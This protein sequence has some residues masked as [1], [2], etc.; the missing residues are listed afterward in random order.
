MA[1]LIGGADGGEEFLGGH[2]GGHTNANPGHH[3]VP[4]LVGDGVPGGRIEGAKAQQRLPHHSVARVAQPGDIQHIDV[5]CMAGRRGEDHRLQPQQGGGFADD[6]R[7]RH[8]VAQALCPGAEEGR[9]DRE[10]AEGQIDLDQA[11]DRTHRRFRPADRTALAGHD[12][13]ADR[14]LARRASPPERLE[15][16]RVPDEDEEYRPECHIG[17]QR[18]RRVGQ[19]RR[20]HQRHQDD[21]QLQQQ[22]DHPRQQTAGHRGN[23]LAQQHRLGRHHRVG[24]RGQP[25]AA[26]VG[27]LWGG[28]HLAHATAVR[29]GRAARGC[30]PAG[31]PRPRVFVAM[32]STLRWWTSTATSLPTVPPGTVST[33]WSEWPGSPP[34]G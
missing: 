3:P 16:R 6:E 10:R 27:E 29:L 21:H 18:L 30:P 31:H 19:E 2:P 24:V 12:A 5:L 34:A 20:R 1:A 26:D 4:E 14:H 25:S 23:R 28:T 7:S 15:D 17:G 13:Q 22:V 8:Q 32:A 33:S 11:G 9:C